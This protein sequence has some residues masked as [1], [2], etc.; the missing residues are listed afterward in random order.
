MR[1]IYGLAAVVLATGL[2]A[3][4]ATTMTVS[5]H[6]E[7]GL[8]FSR[9]RTFDW[10]AADELP[11]GDPRLDANPYFKDYLL[12]AVEKELGRRGLEMSTSPDLRLHYHASVTRRVNVDPLDHESGD[13][14]GAACGTEVTEYDAGTIVLDV[15]DA[16]TNQV[17]WRGWAQ[18]ALRNLLDDRETTARAVETAVTR[19]LAQ[20]PENS[21][22][23]KNADF[24]VHKTYTWATVDRLATGDPRLDNNPF[25]RKALESSVERRLTM[26]GL[27]KRETG[28]AD[29]EV[30]YYASVRQ[31]FDEG[32]ITIDLVDARTGRLVWRGWTKEY[33]D[34]VIDN[35]E[36]LE[37]RI[38][39][40]VSRIMEQFPPKG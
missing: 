8:D 20:F 22:T 38:D 34:G 35:Q 13:C 26:K 18:D 1:R 16:Q 39:K 33:L 3:G 17:V 7:R 24:A 10:E 12:G 21:Y 6:V 27:E 30:R 40:A 2:A 36:R 28:V 11:T 19:M 4:C 25:F 29:F 15:V 31:Q 23:A 32:T 9:Y 37:E 5:S 14:Y